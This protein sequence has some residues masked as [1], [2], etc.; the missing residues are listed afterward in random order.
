MNST[1]QNN[2]VMIMELKTI[3]SKLACLQ[4]YLKL[5]SPPACITVNQK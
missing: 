1:A 2:I 4:R 3:F 5:A